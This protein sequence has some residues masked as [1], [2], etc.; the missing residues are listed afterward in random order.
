MSSLEGSDHSII[1]FCDYVLWL[2]RRWSARLSCIGGCPEGKDIL[3]YEALADKFF[4]VSL[5]VSTVDD[6][7]FLI[8]VVRRI[9]FHSGEVCGRIGSILDL[10]P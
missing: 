5:E 3:F 4:Q 7:V 10:Y 6:L 8:V 1:L 9:F 2:G